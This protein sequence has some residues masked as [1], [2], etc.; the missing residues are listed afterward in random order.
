MQEVPVWLEHF[1]KLG[2]EAQTYLQQLV[3][4]PWSRIQ[5]ITKF[6]YSCRNALLI[7]L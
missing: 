7:S 3:P 5:V 6:Q 1:K 2:K 4:T